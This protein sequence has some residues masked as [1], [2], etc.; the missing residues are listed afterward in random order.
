MNESWTMPFLPGIK[1]KYRIHELKNL[2]EY[3]HLL[4]ERKDMQ[5]ETGGG[6]RKELGNQAAAADL[7]PERQEKSSGEA[8]G[9]GL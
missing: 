1:K 9:K 7:R 4:K 8:Q 6:E 3:I 2:S 5:K